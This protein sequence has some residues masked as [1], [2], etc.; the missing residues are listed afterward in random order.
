MPI[1]R[2]NLVVKQTLGTH[3][4]FALTDLCFGSGRVAGF[5]VR[6]S[7]QLRRALRCRD[8]SLK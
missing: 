8:N 2:E 1:G 6:G 7:T 5:P 4:L 3:T